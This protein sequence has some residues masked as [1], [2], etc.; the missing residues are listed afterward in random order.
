ME[1]FRADGCIKRSDSM[2]KDQ[3]VAI[4]SRLITNE[5]TFTSRVCKKVVDGEFN[6]ILNSSDFASLLNEGPGKKIEVRNLT[7]LMQPL[8]RAGVIKVKNSKERRMKFWLPGWLSSTD[9]D[10]DEK[11]VIF[12]NGENAWTD[13]NKKFPRL[14]E[15]LSGDLCIVDPYYGFG[16]LSALHNFGKGRKIRFLTA[17]MGDED[18]SK[19]GIFKKELQAFKTEFTNVEFRQYGK[20]YE[21]HDRYIIA[22]NGLIIVGGGIKDLARKESF[23]LFVPKKVI[24]THLPVLKKKFEERW[25]KASNLN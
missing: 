25:K 18:K 9:I 16:T 3:V 14:L 15:R 24:G 20:R 4:A 23:V 1:R 2:D 12:F 19:E 22:N 6:S 7:A 21:L 10:L 5:G 13:A 11:E 17:Q 8:L